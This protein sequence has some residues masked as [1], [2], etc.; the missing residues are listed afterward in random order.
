MSNTSQAATDVALGQLTVC[1]IGCA[2]LGLPE[3]VVLAE[4]IDD[5][6]GHSALR[7]IPGTCDQ[8]HWHILGRT[9]HDDFPN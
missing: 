3:N 8:R 2:K 6:I 5:W 4:D 9:K 7:A 1:A